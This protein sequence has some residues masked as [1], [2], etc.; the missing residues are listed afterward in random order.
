[1]DIIDSKMTWFS[2]TEGR[3]AKNHSNYLTKQ[4]FIQLHRKYFQNFKKLWFQSD[5]IIDT[6]AIHTC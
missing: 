4:L 6:L 2:Y 1:M 5:K 3:L